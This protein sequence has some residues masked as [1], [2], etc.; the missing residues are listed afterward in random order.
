[1]KMNQIGFCGHFPELTEDT[2]RKACGR[3]IEVFLNARDL[4]VGDLQ[5]SG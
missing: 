2:G 4:V 1:M 3:Q 5:A